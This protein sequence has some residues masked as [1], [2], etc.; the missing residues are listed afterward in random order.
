MDDVTEP[1]TEPGTEVQGAL[2]PPGTE[3]LG[4]G[5]RVQCRKTGRIGVVSS[6]S[7]ADSSNGYSCTV[8]HHVELS[9]NWADCLTILG[10]A[11]SLT[12]ESLRAQ[13]GCVYTRE[14]LPPVRGFGGG[15]CVLV[16][17]RVLDWVT[18]DGQRVYYAV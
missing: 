4:S 1:G 7:F 17:G 2:K 9:G 11:P 14:T 12:I 8:G 3:V 6:A 16:D 15:M 10:E 18:I 5:T 13:Y